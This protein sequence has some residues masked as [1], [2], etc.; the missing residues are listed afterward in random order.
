MPKKKLPMSG[1]ECAAEMESLAKEFRDSA[2]RLNILADRLR[3]YGVT[4]QV[5]VRDGRVVGLV[6]DG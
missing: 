5:E 2:S 1:D 4:V 3:Q 6:R